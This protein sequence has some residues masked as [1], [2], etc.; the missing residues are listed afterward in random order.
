[1]KKSRDLVVVELSCFFLWSLGGVNQSGVVAMKVTNHTLWLGEGTPFF[2]VD[3]EAPFR[4]ALLQS[5]GSHLK[6]NFIS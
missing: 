1:M 5:I 2:L 6:I 4:L 3:F